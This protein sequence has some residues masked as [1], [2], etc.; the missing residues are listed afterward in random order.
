MS[1]QPKEP[2]DAEEPEEAEQEEQEEEPSG[3]CARY[4]G[5]IC[6]GYLSNPSSVWF[7]ISSDESGGWLNEQLVEGLW[8]EVIRSLALPC[9]SAAKVPSL[10]NPSITSTLLVTYLLLEN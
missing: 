1:Q 2:E 9:Q 4:T 7:N 6:D 8:E 3:Y 5:R 10:S